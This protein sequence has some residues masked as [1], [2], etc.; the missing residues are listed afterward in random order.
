MAASAPDDGVKKLAAEMADEERRHA[1]FIRD[2][3]AKIPA[4]P[5]DWDQDL[6]PPRYSE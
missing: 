1:A 5:A 6:D 2:R 3:L 4:P